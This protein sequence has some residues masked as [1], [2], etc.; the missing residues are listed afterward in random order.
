MESPHGVSDDGNALYTQKRLEKKDEIHFSQS[1]M[2]DY[3]LLQS[4]CL[5]SGN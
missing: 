1:E 3:K 5:K 4:Y 2:L